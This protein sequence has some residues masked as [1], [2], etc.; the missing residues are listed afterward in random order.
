MNKNVIDQLARNSTLLPDDLAKLIL[1]G[2]TPPTEEIVLHLV[3][4]GMDAYF[5]TI[6]DPKSS[7]AEKRLARMALTVAFLAAMATLGDA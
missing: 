1:A 4:A 3:I 6:N 2:T 7:W 5:V